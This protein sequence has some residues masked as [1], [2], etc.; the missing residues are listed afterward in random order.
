MRHASCTSPSVKFIRGHVKIVLGLIKRYIFA[1]FHRVFSSVHTIAIVW[2]MVS[3][4][5][6][7]L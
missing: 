7:A 3:R 2:T 5:L 1:A 4:D 6:H